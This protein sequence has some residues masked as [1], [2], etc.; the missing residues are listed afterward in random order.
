MS[1]S[2]EE[3]G[4][5]ASTWGDQAKESPPKGWDALLDPNIKIGP[6]DL[7]S[8][9]LHRKGKNFK[10]IDEELILA[11]R[12]HIQVPKKK[13]QEAIRKTEQALGLPESTRSNGTKKKPMNK[14]STLPKQ[15]KSAVFST[16]R[17]PPPNPSNWSQ[18]VLVDTPFWEQSEKTMP[19]QE[20]KKEE[21]QSSWAS[22]MAEIN[23]DSNWGALG[24]V[25]SKKTPQETPKET[26]EET[27]SWNNN[28]W[29]TETSWNASTDRPSWLNSIPNQDADSKSRFSNPSKQRYSDYSAP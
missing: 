20:N 9:N 23:A 12:K 14:K 11:Q 16:L 8:G 2:E 19:R 24:S 17:A 13:M 29:G 5:L 22:T 26:K 27:D 15:T 4:P 10:P 25:I 1:D 7:G 3:Y 18:S 6:N 28:H 21:K